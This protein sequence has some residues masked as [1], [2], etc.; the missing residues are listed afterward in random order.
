MELSA[1]SGDRARDAGASQREDQACRRHLTN[2]L[3]PFGKEESERLRDRL[4]DE[5]GS[6]AAALA[7]SPLRRD[8]LLVGHAKAA[9]HLTHIQAAMLHSLR[10][11]ALGGAEIA[12]TE[13]LAHY[14]RADMGF[15]PDEQLRILFLATGNRLVADEVMFQGSIDS[16]S[17]LPR[18]IVHRALELGASG[19]IVVHN[20][21]GGRP[22][23]S[24]ADIEATRE[25]VAACR[26]L[27]IRVHDH[28]I[29]ARGGWTSLRLK[30]L[31]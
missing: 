1:A 6:L 11:E 15:R 4:V 16:A 30:G 13:A 20:H 7:A 18:P 19:I 17:V 10:D 8:R 29:V 28:L 31:L 27:E 5:F 12:G 22:E 21:P 26:P 24:R 9:Q 23:P 3:L 14:L 2:L 25:L